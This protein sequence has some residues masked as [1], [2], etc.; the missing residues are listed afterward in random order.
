MQGMRRAGSD[1]AFIKRA[2]HAVEKSAH[3]KIVSLVE[4]MLGLHKSLA[5]VHSLLEK[6]WQIKSTDMGIDKFVYELYG[7]TEEIRVVEG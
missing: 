1:R 6:E 2:N 5:S 4:S 3:D 7:L